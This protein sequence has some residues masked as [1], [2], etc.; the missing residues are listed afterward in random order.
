MLP[1][2]LIRLTPVYRVQR[3][4]SGICVKIATFWVAS[5]HAIYRLMH[6]RQGHVE[7]EGQF[8]PQQ[9]YLVL[10]NHQAWADIQILFDELHPYTPFGRFFLKKELIWVPI[11]GVVCW[12]MDFPFMRRHSRDV[13]AKNPELAQQDLETTKKACEIYKAQPVT[14]INFLE[15]TR[16]NEKKR[17]KSK[18]RFLHLL[19][20]KYGGLT[21]SLNAMGDQFKGIVDVTIVYQ[22]AGK[23]ITW[24]WLCGRQ[25]DMKIHIKI[26]PIPQEMVDGDYRND[27]NFKSAFKAWIGQIWIEK[28]QRITDMKA[29]LREQNRS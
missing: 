7:I 19:N 2:I 15:G 23:N 8:E 10:S 14:V 25:K 20:P 12:A 9:S 27:S 11:V 3:F 4:A 18:S 17:D 24:S 1:F 5:N 21:A 6:G 13:L 16:F 26:R 28:D 22:P 29:E